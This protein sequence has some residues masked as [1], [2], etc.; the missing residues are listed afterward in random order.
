MQSNKPNVTKNNALLVFAGLIA[1]LV[2]LTSFV[3]AL[4]KFDDGGKIDES[5]LFESSEESVEESVAES[6]E[7]QEESGEYAYYGKFEMENHP[8]L[9]SDVVNGPLAIV[10]GDNGKFPNVDQASLVNV[11]KKKT[12]NIYGL[13]NTSLV[14]YEEAIVN[15]DR[16]IVSFY[17]YLPK[18]G[19]IIDK[20]YTTP[21]VV[22]LSDPNV[23]L[24]TGYSVKLFVYNSSYNFGSEEFAYLKDQAFRYGVIQRYPENKESYTGFEANGSIYRYVG[25][26]H[27]AYMNHY[28]HSLEEYIDKIRTNK[29]IEFESELEEN[30]SY[31]VYYVPLSTSVETTYVPLPADPDYTYTISGDGSSG[32]IVT[33]RVPTK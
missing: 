13:S 29:V 14:M 31:V 2:M 22:T 17:D 21:E 12:S 7:P 5:S 19:L 27:S 23:D 24:A 8:R 10:K 1:A 28:R 25:L 30:V 26:A 16:F 32:F 9:N 6:S 4:S 11:S 15:I 20:A 3:M 18:N 33:V